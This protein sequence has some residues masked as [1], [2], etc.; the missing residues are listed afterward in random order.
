MFIKVYDGVLYM[1]SCQSGAD[2]L[3]DVAKCLELAYSVG[4]SAED[5]QESGN[6][7]LKRNVDQT[8]WEGLQDRLAML[9]A[10]YQS[11]EKGDRYALAYLPGQGTT[12]K[13]NG[14][15]LVTI[16]GADFANAYFSIWLGEDAAKKSFRDDLLGN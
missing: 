12:L 7:I 8:T 13:L 11:V 1:D 16:E 2:P 6:A 10:A 9:N 14:V 4:L 3:T 5:F 15:P